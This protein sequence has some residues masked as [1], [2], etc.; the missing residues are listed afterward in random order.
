[1]L[2]YF[3]PLAASLGP[4]SALVIGGYFATRNARPE[5]ARKD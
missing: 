5:R 2:A 3:A 4:V 1:M